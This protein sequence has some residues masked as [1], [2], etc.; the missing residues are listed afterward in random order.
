I[1]VTSELPAIT[2]ALAIDGF[3]QPGSA[4]NTLMA[5]ND[6]VM[7]I[8]LHGGYAGLSADGLVLNSGGS[9]IR[10]LVINGFERSG[11]VIQGGTGGNLI[12]GNF[13][14][15]N[16]TGTAALLNGSDGI[17][18]L[19]SPSNRIGGASPGARNLISGND[20]DAIFIDGA[21]SDGTIIQGNYL[22]TNAAGTAAI[23]NDNHAIS[24]TN[25]AD[26]TLVGGALPGEGNLISGNDGYAV[27]MSEFSLPSNGN[28]VLGNLIGSDATGLLP[29]PNVDGRISIFASSNN[30]IGG[31]GAGAGNRIAFNVGDGI[32]VLGGSGRGNSSGNAFMGNTIIGNS[33]SGINMSGDGVFV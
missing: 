6:A 19:D 31:T 25:G 8:G 33:V 21:T 26:D 27:S 28:Q 17:D 11:I 16:A 14:G 7:L 10:G 22:G 32:D 4:P 5:G 30:V 2:E 3:T 24:I 13:I 29:L 12:E 15:T 18:V 9:I 23:L 20:G 1:A